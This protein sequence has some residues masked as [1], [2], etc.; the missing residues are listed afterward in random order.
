MG[1]S[2]IRF[3]LVREDPKIATDPHVDEINFDW[4]P[5]GSA[6]VPS[7]LV[8]RNFNDET[9]AETTCEFSRG[10]PRRSMVD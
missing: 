10:M 3:D 1:F 7:L 8:N 2:C 5:K 6:I 4:R 9:K